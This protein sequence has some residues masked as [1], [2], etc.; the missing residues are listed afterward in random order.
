MRAARTITFLADSPPLESPSV[1]TDGDSRR[2][3][4]SRTMISEE[5]AR[6]I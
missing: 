3:R 2:L 1:S 4:T 5:R 6:L